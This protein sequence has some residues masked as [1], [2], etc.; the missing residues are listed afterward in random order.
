VRTEYIF[1]ALLMR[2][3]LGVVAFSVLA[4]NKLSQGQR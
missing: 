4:V 1:D 2:V 3:C